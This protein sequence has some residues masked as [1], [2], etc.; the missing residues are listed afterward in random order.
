MGLLSSLLCCSI[1]SKDDNDDKVHRPS[2]SNGIAT[3]TSN[4]SNAAVTSASLKGNSSRNNQQDK[5]KKIN[6]TTTK[7]TKANT[8]IKPT[9][10]TSKLQSKNTPTRHGKDANTNENNSDLTKDNDI[11]VMGDEDEDEEDEVDALK[12]SK[13]DLLDDDQSIN[14]IETIAN[15]NDESNNN[16]PKSSNDTTKTDTNNT[17][18]NTSDIITQVPENGGAYTTTNSSNNYQKES[19]NLVQK[20]ETRN[21]E[22]DDE[23]EEDEDKDDDEDDESLEDLTKLQDGQAFNPETGYLLGKKDKNFGNKKCLI[24]DLDETLVHSSFKYLRNA[25]FVI[26][27]E[28]DNQIHH[29][30]VVKRPGVDEFLQKMGKLYEVVVFTASVL[31][32]GDPLL[33]KLDIYNSVHHRLFR[34]SCYNYQGNF[35]KNLSQ[36]G[37]P[38]EDTIIIDNSPASYIFHPDHSIPISSWFSDLHDNELLD[39]IPFLEDLAKPIVDDVGLVLDISL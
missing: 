27:V 38:L 16:T 8:T 1:E 2:T 35:I 23:E 26:P 30:Y 15:T 24:L 37:R 7:T 12:P 20:N 14:E 33:D 39:L 28:I 10:N 18:I 6:T 34:D 4:K 5:A 29:V 3:T 25:D 22:D 13:K 17:K 31:K 32:Y 21:G 11:D 36:I 19:R 9:T